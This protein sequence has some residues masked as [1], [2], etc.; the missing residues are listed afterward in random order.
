MEYYAE[1]VIVTITATTATTHFLNEVN[2]T[3]WESNL[4]N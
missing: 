3:T 2:Q 4:T 1:C